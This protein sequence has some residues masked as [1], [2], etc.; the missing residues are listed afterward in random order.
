[1][2]RPVTGCDS[3]SFRGRDEG[4][5]EV[6][7]DIKAMALIALGFAVWLMPGDLIMGKA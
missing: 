6:P 1:M 2:L 4:E 7:A 5:E 3:L